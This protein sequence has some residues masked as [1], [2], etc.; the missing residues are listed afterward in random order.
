MSYCR[1][2]QGIMKFEH[3]NNPSNA[4]VYA[5]GFCCKEC[6]RN[7]EQEKEWVVER[8]AAKRP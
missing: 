6:A 8:E 7:Y 2:C 3:I 1:F 4:K 5:R